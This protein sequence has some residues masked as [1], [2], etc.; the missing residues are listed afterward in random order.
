MSILQTHLV[1]PAA[2]PALYGGLAARLRAIRRFERL[3]GKRQRDLQQEWLRRLLEHAYGTVPYYR[4]Q[5]Q[6]AGVHPSSLRPGQPIPI[7]E[8]SP[9]TFRAQ[10]NLL[11]S[12][13]YHVKQSLLASTGAAHSSAAD[14]LRDQDAAHNKIALNLQLNRWAGYEPGDT[15]LTLLGPEEHRPLPGGRRSRFY[16]ELLMHRHQAICANFEDATLEQVRMQ[17]ENLRPKVLCGGSTVLARFAS[18]LQRHGARHRPKIVVAATETLSDANRRLMESVFGL[19]IFVHYA[20]RGIGVV[21][22]ECPDHEGLHFHPW[23]SFV[24]FD[25]IA[26][27]PQGTACRLIVTDLL[28]YGQ[29]LIRY[30]TGDCVIL[31]AQQC[32]CGSWFPLV[33][34][35]VD[36]ATLRRGMQPGL[37]AIA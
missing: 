28:N 23:G 32:S 9:A 26:T 14:F 7:A 4:K 35:F 15:V 11:I 29:P 2:D 19:Q 30:D 17:Y 37:H 5:F 31:A 20:C 18:Y 6:E 8:L 22:A 34:K 24:E 25:P 12:S 21:A 3:P 16:E 13:A 36:P 1:M 33:D 10:S 27:T